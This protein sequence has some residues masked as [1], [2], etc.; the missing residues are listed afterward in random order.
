MI[1]L[2]INLLIMAYLTVYLPFVHG[3]D[4]DFDFE[5]DHPKLIPVVTIFGILCFFW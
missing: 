5:K 1:S 4:K 2:G 3:S